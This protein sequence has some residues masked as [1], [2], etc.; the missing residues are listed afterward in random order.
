M[1]LCLN[2]VARAEVGS[3]SASASPP[4]TTYK[5]TPSFYQS[6][7]ANHAW[8]LNLRANRGSDA[9]WLGIYRDHQDY[10]QARAGY[11]FTQ[12]FD[13]GQIV[14]SGQLAGGGFV[15]GS[16][17][18]QFG[19]AA[20]VI[21]GLGRTNLRSYYNL[22]FDP[23]DALTL[24]AGSHLDAATDV[25]LYHIWDDRLGTRQHVT[26]FYLHRVLEGGRRFS[27]DGAYKS[28]L[29]GNSALVRG[30]SFTGTFAFGQRFVRLA[31]DRHANFGMA[32]QNRISLGM[33]F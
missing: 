17:N 19:D 32:D 12:A 10:Q 26:H 24:G 18:G 28:G 33:T 5:L 1:S 16:V 31:H 22:N 4:A 21:I 23:N 7:D 25:S 11:E 13:A 15:G 6:S 27:L 9:A 30:V 8:D 14:W 20:Y 3:E 2:L 29:D